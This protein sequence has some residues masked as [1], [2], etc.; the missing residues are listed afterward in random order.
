MAH[1]VSDEVREPVVRS[2][3]AVRLRAEGRWPED[4]DLWHVSFDFDGA[5]LDEAP[6]L[7]TAERERAARF[8]QLAD[9]VRFASTRSVLRELLGHYL[10]I[11]PAAVPLVVSGRGKPELAGSA[12]GRLS[13][14]VSHS[15]DHALIAI[16]SRRT[17]GID[18][19]RIDAAINWRELAA[20]VCTP[21]E[22]QAIEGSSSEIQPVQFFRCWTAK[23]ALLKALGLGITAGLLAL[24]VDPREERSCGQPQVVDG[25]HAFE[26]A[27]ALRYGWLPDIDGYLGCLA[28]ECDTGACSP[29]FAE[30]QS[31]A[32]S[33]KK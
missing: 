23:E 15:G 17:V 24:R 20:L 25:A 22:R 31:N 9:Q 18:I 32:N 33:E 16:S 27:R 14:N 29:K 19:E 3:R 11:D 28:Y 7:D 4:I 8:H 10:R 13:F 1:L 2:S 26:G 5:R 21:S 6:F 30:P 12:C